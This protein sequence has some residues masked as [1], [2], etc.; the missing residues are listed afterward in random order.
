MFDQKFADQ[1][2]YTDTIKLFQAVRAH[3]F[4][5]LAT[6]CDDDFGIIDIDPDGKS[7]LIENREEWE[8]WF[9]TLFARL[10][11]MQ[12]DTDTQILQYQ[13]LQS[14]DMGYSVVNFCQTLT[15]LGYT[16]YFTCVATIIWKR[17]DST[18]R[19]SRWHCSLL[20]A[21]TSE[22]DALKTLETTA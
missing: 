15:V 16:G 6:L 22:L 3:D 18:W 4:D 20:R 21:D 8:Q 17:V 12:A 5:T 2:F 14:G 1:P 9:H 7:V 13:A 10:D 19:E 11:E